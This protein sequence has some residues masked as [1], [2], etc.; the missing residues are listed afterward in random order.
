VTAT[1]KTRGRGA[2]R[3]WE[4]ANV[5]LLISLLGRN[6]GISLSRQGKKE[7]GK[8]KQATGGI[9]GGG[10]PARFVSIRPKTVEGGLVFCFS[11]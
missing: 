3:I 2:R 4:K 10:G 5:F 9:K 11:D 6:Y 1:G 7:R 8:W